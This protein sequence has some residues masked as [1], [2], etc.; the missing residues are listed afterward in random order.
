M[1]GLILL[2]CIKTEQSL[3][4]GRGLDVD[5]DRNYLYSLS[6]VFVVSVVLMWFIPTP[7][8]VLYICVMVCGIEKYPLRS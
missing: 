8:C 6:P 4:L 5:H 1:E 2:H 7:S 3:F